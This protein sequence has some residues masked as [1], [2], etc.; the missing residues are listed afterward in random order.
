MRKILFSIVVFISISASAQEVQLSWQKDLNTAKNVANAENKSVLIYFTKSDCATCQQFYND[1]FK[2]DEFKKLS[3]SF[4]LVI[5]DGSNQDIQST[6]LNV[7][8]QRRWAMHYNKA[9]NFPAVLTI[10]SEGREKG[11]LMTSTSPDA[12]EAY[13]NFLETL[14]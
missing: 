7:I 5:L 6:D 9:L 12:I 8:K 2:Q 13:W 1:F 14:K 3:D 10:D 11:D 4:V